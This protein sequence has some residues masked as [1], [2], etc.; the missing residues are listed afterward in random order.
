MMSLKIELERLYKKSINTQKDTN[1]ERERAIHFFLRQT[2]LN[3][4]SNERE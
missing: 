3:S 4:I 2:F 1:T